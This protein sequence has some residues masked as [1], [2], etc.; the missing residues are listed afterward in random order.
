MDYL[1]DGLGY[2]LIK[3]HLPLSDAQLNEA[4]QY[5]ASHREELENDYAQ[6]V[7]RSEERRARYEQLYRART[8][9]PPDLPNA[10]KAKLMRRELA[11]KQKDSRPAHEDNH[12]R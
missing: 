12:T 11:R 8:E 9:L 10:E 4:L 2:E 1:K 3:Q 5:L 7:H 6:I